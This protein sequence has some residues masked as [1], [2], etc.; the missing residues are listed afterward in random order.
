[1]AEVFGKQMTIDLV[2]APTTRPST[3][4]TK[5][6]TSPTTQR[7]G[8]PFAFGGSNGA[9]MNAFRDKTFKVAKVDSSPDQSEV[10]STLLAV[11]GA[12]LRRMNLFAPSLLYEPETKHMVVPV[13]GRMLYE[14]RRGGPATAPAQPATAPAQQANNSQLNLRGATAFEWQKDFIYDDAAHQATMSG[15]VDV[16]HKGTGPTDSYRMHAQ[17]VVAEMMPSAATNP[18]ATSQPSPDEAKL[19]NLIADGGVTFAS[20]NLQFIADRVEYDPQTQIL[21]AR[22]TERAPATLL[23]SN[24]LSQNTFTEL[25]YDVRTDRLEM[26]GSRGT[27]RRMSGNN[28]NGNNAVTGSNPESDK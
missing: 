13:A 28:N 25:R 3:R 24:G 17:R 15:D 23:D 19:K 2:D 10:R 16:V 6:A 26:S 12:I 5:Q 20:A 18:S 14:D 8:N 11:D 7:S 22:G 1:M 9:D 21:I 4:P 27:I